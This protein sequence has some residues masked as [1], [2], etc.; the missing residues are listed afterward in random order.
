MAEIS[1]IVPVYQAEKFLEACVE[2]VLSQDFQDWELLLV[3]DGSTDGSNAICRRYASADSRIRLIE[4]A[5]GGVS[6][7]RNTGLDRASAR[8]VTFLDADDELLPGALSWLHDVAVRS[9]AEIVTGKWI[10]GV[11]KP[12]VPS[13]TYHEREVSPRQY[14]IDMLY[15]K[16]YAG[17]VVWSCLFATSLFHRVRFDKLK[18]EDLEIL[19]RLLGNAR[20]MILTD[21]PVYFY[22]DNPSSFINTWSEGR[23]DAVRVTEMFQKAFEDDPV[24]CRA[25]DNRHFRSNF[26]LLLGL[27]ENCPDDRKGIEECYAEIKKLRSDVIKDPSS[28]LSTRLGALLSYIGLRG[29]KAFRRLR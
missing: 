9:G 29:I 6:E 13:K 16:R 4:Q 11:D 8:Y 25:V 20:R 24:M 15:R 22:R 2:S 23:R 21:R 17:S 27:L 26:N 10:R 3:D 12:E 14:C 7:A 19:P 18:Y 28:L 5:N 1:V